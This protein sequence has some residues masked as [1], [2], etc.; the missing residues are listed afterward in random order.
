MVTTIDGAAFEL[1][2][3]AVAVV[4]ATYNPHI[5]DALT[6]AAFATLQAAGI[7]EEH[8][9][10]VKVPGAWEIPQ[11]VLPLLET[12][13]FAGIV[14][15]G[16]V[17]R[18]ET[19]HDQHLNRAISMRLAEL[20]SEYHVPIGMGVLMCNDVEQ[21]LQ[22][23]GGAMGNKGEEAAEAVIAMIRA[24]RAIEHWATETAP[25]ACAPTANH[26]GGC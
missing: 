1:A 17:I 15:L 8:L 20:S 19:T 16:A 26:S 9:I 12:R 6:K 13:R 5:T 21:A 24:Q 3:T 25:P 22:R 23:S 7:Q 10:W 14:C 4:Q 11:A 18:G 2:G